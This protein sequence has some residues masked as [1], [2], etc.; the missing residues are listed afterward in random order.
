[1]YEYKA[2][3]IRVVDGD[4][5]CLHVDLGFRLYAE[6]DFRLA[7][8]NAPELTGPKADVAA[9]TRAK[10]YLESLLVGQLTITTDR[11][12]KYGRWLVTIYVPTGE[13]ANQLMVSSGNAVVYP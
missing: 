4:T 11:P 2:K 10:Q 12:D 1:M 5:V 6:L 9:A 7:G 3:L 13:S 8:I